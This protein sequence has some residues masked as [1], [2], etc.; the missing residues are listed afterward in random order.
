[1][2]LLLV[3]TLIGSRWHSAHQRQCQRQPLPQQWP[4]SWHQLW[5]PQWPHY[6][7]PLPA[8]RWPRTTLRPQPHRR[9]HK[10]PPIW[11]R[12]H[13]RWPTIQRRFHQWVCRRIRGRPH[14]NAIYREQ[15][16]KRE[17]QIGDE[18]TAF[19]F[20]IFWFLHQRLVKE[21]WNSNTLKSGTFYWQWNAEWSHT[22]SSEPFSN[23]T[24]ETRYTQINIENKK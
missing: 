11:Q 15:R 22:C 13:R 14:P 16:T 23:W 24:T 3:S 1:M 6:S 17:V 7:R 12:S 10:W 5:Q 19:S 9:Y 2:N 21:M 18:L 20:L 4:A 8:I